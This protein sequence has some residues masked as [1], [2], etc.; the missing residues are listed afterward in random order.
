MARKPHRPNAPKPKAPPPCAP[1]E[2]EVEEGAPVEL[3][4]SEERGPGPRCSA[5]MRAFEAL[6]R[7]VHE[8]G[9]VPEALQHGNMTELAN[10]FRANRDGMVAAIERMQ[11]RGE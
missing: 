3:D 8:L 10:S 7:F 4:A 1:E 9:Q 2:P 6:E 5:H 11:S